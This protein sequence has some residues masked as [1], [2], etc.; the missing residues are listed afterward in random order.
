MFNINRTITNLLTGIS[1]GFVSGLL[2]INGVPIEATVSLVVLGLLL[3]I[4]FNILL[5][6]EERRK[7]TPIKFDKKAIFKEQMKESYYNLLF[8]IPGF[9]TYILLITKWQP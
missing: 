5:K 9:I 7:N 2:D 6:K 1:F 4:L 3:F 8:V